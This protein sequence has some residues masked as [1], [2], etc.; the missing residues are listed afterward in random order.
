MTDALHDGRIRAWC[1][2][3]GT[4]PLTFATDLLTVVVIDAPLYDDLFGGAVADN[5]EGAVLPPRPFTAESVD[6]LLGEHPVQAAGVALLRLARAHANTLLGAFP[7]GRLPGPLPG[8]P[9]TSR[10]F[11]PGVYQP[12]SRHSSRC[13][14]S[15]PSVV[16]LPC[17]GYTHV[18]S[19]SGPKSFSDTSLNSDWKRSGSFCV[20]PTPPG[21]TI[22]SEG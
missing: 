17:P 2:G 4:D 5:A 1:L 22:T 21:K 9:F 20:L 6:R 18:S 3:L 19:G 16:S 10:A 13:G 8:R 11:Q 12:R 7:A 15:A 14:R